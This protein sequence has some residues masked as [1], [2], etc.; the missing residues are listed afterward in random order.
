MRALLL[1]LVLAAWCGALGVGFGVAHAG[2]RGACTPAVLASLQPKPEADTQVAADIASQ[3]CKVWPH[4]P[5]TD[6]ATVAYVAQSAAAADEDRQIDLVTAMIDRASGRVLASHRERVEE[7]AVLHVGE[8]ALRLDSAPY[9]L[10]PGMRAIG[11]IVH[12][13]APGASCPDCW[14]ND[15][16]TLFVRDGDPLRPVL[17]TL[18]DLWSRS[19]ASCVLDK[20]YRSANAAITIALGKGTSSGFN[21]LELAAKVET[22]VVSNGNVERTEHRRVSRRLR[23]DGHDYGLDPYQ[24]LF[25]WASE[26][27]SP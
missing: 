4:D 19:S 5:A 24:D 20:S 7:D 14:F 17:S 25:F 22:T 11:R 15:Q 13:D 9:D 10:A 6:L 2:E 3:A 8:D 21:D 26:S 1:H 27:E 12:S 16:V 23:Y 18:L